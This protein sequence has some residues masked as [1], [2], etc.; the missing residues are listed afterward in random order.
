MDT[1]G[2]LDF[3]AFGAILNQRVHEI[4][5]KVQASKRF[6]GLDFMGKYRDLPIIEVRIDFPVYRLANGRTRTFQSEYLALHPDMPIDLFS[7]DHDSYAAQVAQHRILQ[8]LSEEENL[9]K[10]FKN[11]NLIQTEP[12]ICSNNGVVVNGNRR[13]C[14]WRD[15]YYGDNSK[16]KHFQTITIAILPS[17]DERAI[18]E[19]E[20]RLQIQN[21]MRAEYHW[22]TLALMAKD[23][24]QRGHKEADVARSFDKS[25]QTLRL[26][27]DSRDYAEQYLEHIGKPNQWSLVD[28]SYYAF[29]QMV[30][31]RKKLQ[32]QGDK[33]LFESLAFVFVKS[34]SSD[35][36][37]Y[38]VIPDIADNLQ[39]IARELTQKV[40]PKE[41]PVIIN[42][43]IETL[44]GDDEEDT[45]VEH[46]SFVAAAIRNS[47]D[48]SVIQKT[49]INVIETQKQIKQ[50][51]SAENYLLLQ[52]SKAVSA[53]QNAIDNGINDRRVNLDG[54]DKQLE[55][56]LEKARAIKKWLDDQL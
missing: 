32:L 37:L 11:D 54:V 12:L 25:A 49:A 8:K 36:R 23:E 16:Y 21:A 4:S 22:H 47:N 55:A 30:K 14:V 56:V 9:L 28:K 20:K 41:M 48:V 43:A 51:E 38:E 46:S 5:E 33:E 17:C 15:L 42:E 35:G 26:L 24:I 52:I 10:A 3:S 50:E 2:S 19:L 27:L 31:G 39:P 40:F 44:A 45:Q 53:L 34:G 13:L 29:E 18:E 7:R 6:F 1:R